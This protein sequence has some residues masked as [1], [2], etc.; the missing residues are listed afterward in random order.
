MKSIILIP[1]VAVILIAGSF[2]ALAERPTC[3]RFDAFWDNNSAAFAVNGTDATMNGIIDGTT[4]GVVAA[5]LRDHPAVDTIILDYVP[6]SD[7]DSANV[8]AAQMI[9]AAGL[10]THIKNNGVVSSG[11]VDF[12]L[13]GVNRTIDAGVC[14]VGVHSWAGGGIANPAALPRSSVEHLLYLRY[15]RRMGIDEEFYFF[16]LNAASANNIYNMDDTDIASFGMTGAA[17]VFA[18]E[19]PDIRIGKSGNSSRQAG[20]NQYS[21]SGKRQ[22][23]K[24]QLKKTR[25]AKF[26]LTIENDSNAYDYMKFK[27]SRAGRSLRMTVFRTSGRRKNITGSVAKSGFLIPSVNPGEL[28][29]FQV[30]IKNAS[31]QKKGR[32]NFKFTGSSSLTGSKKDVAVAKVSSR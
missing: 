1:L 9:R 6:G 27:S 32:Q 28:A 10:N 29:K 21:N 2:S 24:V 12:F 17:V 26:N 30:L 5:L 3:N 8:N 11:G 19:R 20:N 25:P 15:Y 4:P 16:T 23:L 18:P 7:N 22:T 13:A 31:S 14:E